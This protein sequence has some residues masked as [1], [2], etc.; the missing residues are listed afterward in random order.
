MNVIVIQ[1]SVIVNLAMEVEHVISVSRVISTSHCAKVCMPITFLHHS[2][3]LPYG[4]G[5][6]S[7]M[8]AIWLKTFK[9]DV[10]GP[11]ERNLYW[12]AEA[13]EARKN[14]GPGACPRENFL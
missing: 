7:V 1:A 3:L 13:S 6:N 10:T 14:G 4:Q 11:S 2:T 9:C 12:G 5:S 8:Q